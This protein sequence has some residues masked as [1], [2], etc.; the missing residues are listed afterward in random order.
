MKKSLGIIFITLFTVTFLHAQ[1]RIK[2]EKENGIYTTP[3]KVNGLQLRFIFDTGASN[4]S[5][6]LSEA[7]FM[8]KNGYLADTD[9]HGS[10]YSQIANGDIIENTSINIRELEIGGIKLFNVSAIIVH[11]LSAPL[12]LGQSA[13]QK[14]GK[15]QLE[16][17]EL[18]IINTNDQ[19]GSY[20]PID[21]KPLIKKAQ[22]Y[23]FDKLYSLSSDTYEWA[24]L[25]SPESFDCFNLFLMAASFYNCN[26][27]EQCIKYSH[28][29]SK[30]TSDK[31]QLFYTYQQIGDSYRK[32]ENYEQASIY[33]ERAFTYSSDGDQSSLIFCSL[34]LVKFFSEK[35]NQALLDFQNSLYFFMRQNDIKEEDFIHGKYKNG[36]LGEIYFRISCTYMALYNERKA[37]INAAKSAMLGYEAAIEFCRI[38]DIDY[39][40]Y[41][42][43]KPKLHNR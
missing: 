12:L 27:Y 34:G 43:G 11:E 7:I 10:T 32:L 4:V 33:L 37:H 40:F 1:V 9:L 42:Q 21:L 36:Y 41:F 16:G 20:S 38:H 24:Y 3:C 35:Y 13:I 29:A 5:I 17:D 8:L 28:K 6:S 15:I 26:L 25:L 31:N 19:S 18:V 39:K 14:L 23:Y 30:C 22:G 2:M